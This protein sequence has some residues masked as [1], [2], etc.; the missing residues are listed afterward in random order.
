[1]STTLETRI[2]RQTP[3]ERRWVSHDMV[4]LYDITRESGNALAAYC[5][6]ARRESKEPDRADYWRER[7]RAI[8][9][10]IKELDPKNRLALLG[11]CDAWED[12]LEALK[13]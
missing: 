3:R 6:R 7:E 8:V 13:G 5:Y 4:S 9:R 1:M 10:R 11:Q 2:R 12:E